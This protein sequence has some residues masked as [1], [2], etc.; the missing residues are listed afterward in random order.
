M[1]VCCLTT[2]NPNISRLKEGLSSLIGQVDRL[3]VIDNNSENKSFIENCCRI[4]KVEFISLLENV[5]IAKAQNIVWNRA[6]NDGVEFIVFADQDTVFPTDFVASLIK[7]LNDMP[8]VAAVAP[9]FCDKNSE[10]LVEVSVNIFESPSNVILTPGRNRSVSHVISSGMIVNNGIASKIGLNR[11]ELFIDWVDTEWCWRAYLSGFEIIQ[12]GDVVLEHLLGE[13]KIIISGKQLT[14]HKLFRSYYKIRNGIILFQNIKNWTIKRHLF[15][16]SIKNILLVFLS[17]GT[18][19]AKLRLIQR[20]I[21]DGI[22]KKGGK[23]E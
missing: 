11:E 15:Q 19:F 20:S 14:R 17:S 16:H 13:D 21:I 5:G 1:I 8:N 2:F 3:I 6:I 10:R 4:L 7:Y 18:L 12:T 22:L 23:F 9:V